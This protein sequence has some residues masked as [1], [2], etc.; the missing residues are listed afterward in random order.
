M[1][2]QERIMSVFP[3][4]QLLIK[5]IGE[6]GTKDGADYLSVLRK[7]IQQSDQASLDSLETRIKRLVEMLEDIKR[8]I[9]IVPRTRRESPIFNDT[10]D[11]IIYKLK[12]LA[13]H[14]ATENVRLQALQTLH[15]IQNNP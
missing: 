2:E 1:S 11:W 14:A 13:E 7:M 12:E 8:F 10:K 5:V 6:I 9:Y 3:L 4:E 15:K